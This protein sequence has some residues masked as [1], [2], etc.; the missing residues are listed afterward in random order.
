M[1]GENASRNFPGTIQWGSSSLLTWAWTRTEI[2][3]AIERRTREG[4][5]ARL[6][7]RNLL[8]V[9]EGFADKWDEVTDVLSVRARANLLA[10][11]SLRAADAG[12]LAAAML[13]QE[14]MSSPLTF[15]C[16]D[17]RLSIAAELEG[18]EVMP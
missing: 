14:Q 6:E 12:Q 5:F 13:V 2:V 15:V 1:T 17:Q 11:H 8:R 3:S 18:L 16:L 9:F 4:A 10:R 7:R